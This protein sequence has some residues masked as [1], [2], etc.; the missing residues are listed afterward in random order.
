[1]YERDAWD[2]KVTEW[3]DQAGR[4]LALVAWACQLFVWLARRALWALMWAGHFVSCFMLRQ[5]EYDADRYEAARC[6]ERN[7]RADRRPASG[8]FAGQPGGAFRPRPIVAGEP[9][10]RRPTTIDP[11]ER[12]R[13]SAGALRRFLR[14]LASQAALETTKAFA[15]HPANRDRIAS[16]ARER[17]PGLF[18][19]EAP[20]TVLFHDYDRIAREVTLAF[21]KDVIGPE[22]E[23]RNLIPT[24]RLIAEHADRLEGHKAVRRYLQGDVSSEYR[25]FLGPLDLSQSIEPS[26]AKEQIRAARERM[27]ET[28]TRYQEAL[29]AF[30]EADQNRDR[31]ESV[32]TRMAGGIRDDAS[33][34]K[35]SAAGHA[36][37]KQ[38]RESL[39]AVR[40]ERLREL[41]EAAQPIVDR[42]RSAFPLLSVPEIAAQVGD[43]GAPPPHTAA[44]YS[45][46]ESA[47]S[48]LA[49]HR[50][51]AS[52]SGLA[53]YS[54]H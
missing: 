13:A 49:A 23:P 22:V 37:A 35:L 12:R 36:A 31:A 40:T 32:A 2:Q 18:Q 10:G 3:S 24:A 19:I 15:T 38:A 53:G 54:V 21:Y 34:L 20:A 9:L 1:M 16:A 44:S 5:M 48:R 27:L 17:A 8:A 52:Q 11:R 28:L 14:L 6:R 51:S 26:Q 30:L 41:D 45:M 39:G 33:G 43:G 50:K 29:R 25:L 47:P 7:V 4:E 42:M 46:R